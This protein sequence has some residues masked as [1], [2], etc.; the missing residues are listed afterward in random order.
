MTPCWLVISATFGGF[1]SPHL[2]HSRIITLG[3]VLCTEAEF[4]ERDFLIKGFSPLWLRDSKVTPCLPLLMSIR[5]WTQNYAI[6][7]LRILCNEIEVFD[8]R[9]KRIVCSNSA[10]HSD[11]ISQLFSLYRP[12]WA[13]AM[14]SYRSVGTGIR[15]ML[16]VFL[17]TMFRVEVWDVFES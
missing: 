15:K 17:H 14:L 12:V 2:Q 3:N 8:C 7:W 11:V 1:C 13:D 4:W 10:C 16:L 6:V 5:T 9:S